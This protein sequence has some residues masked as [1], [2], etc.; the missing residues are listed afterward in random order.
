[1]LPIN[2]ESPNVFWHAMQQMPDVMQERRDNQVIWGAFLVCLM[3]GLQRML[4]L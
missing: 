2:S 4:Q 3:R 1:M